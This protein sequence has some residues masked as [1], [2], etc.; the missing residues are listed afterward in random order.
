MLCVNLAFPSR[1]RRS[2]ARRTSC[3]CSILA[4]SSR[5]VCS[6]RKWTLPCIPCRCLCTG[7][8][9]EVSVTPTTGSFRC[10]CLSLLV[11]R[12]VGAWENE[13]GIKNSLTHFVMPYVPIFFV[14]GKVSLK[15]VL[16]G[17]RIGYTHFTHVIH[18]ESRSSTS[19]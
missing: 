15:L 1:L 11:F 3:P 9:Q 10:V 12:L 4:S 19:V 13:F 2:T 17:V 7:V 18:L 5:A 6:I 16:C 8:H 14:I